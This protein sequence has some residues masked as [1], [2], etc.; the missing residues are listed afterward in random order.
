MKRLNGMWAIACVLALAGFASAKAADIDPATY[1]KGKTITLVVDFKTGGGTD[2]QARYFAAHW[3]QFIPGN[4]RISVTNLFPLPAGRN[5]VWK[6]KPDGTAISFL[7]SADVGSELIA[8][9]GQFQTDKFNYIG[10]HTS[11]DLILY[12]RG[13]VPYK[14]LKDAKGGSVPITVA[15]SVSSPGDLSAIALAT[16]VVSLWMDAPLKIIPIAQG[17]TADSLL[18]MERGDINGWIGGAQW[19][20]LPRLRP[21]WLKDGFIRPLADMSN[22]D[23]EPHPNAEGSLDIPNAITWMT[24]EQKKIWRAIILSQVLTGKALATSPGTPPAVV[25]ILRESYVAALKDPEFAAGIEKI[26]QEPIALYPGEKLQQTIET[27]FAE[28]KADLPEYKKLQK[29]VYDRFV[30]GF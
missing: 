8:T 11:R 23:T 16:G 5:F 14:T 22:P 25:K 12:V 18:M 15:E 19:Y 24:D 30:K 10:A 17:G 27:S 7:A 4:P 3:G 26:Q 13:T 2:V 1:F 9:T 28:F 21:G 20:V 6:S 29:E